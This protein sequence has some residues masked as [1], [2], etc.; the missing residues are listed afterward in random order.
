M[1]YKK[2]D[3]PIKTVDDSKL[4][5]AN[6]FGFQADSI[7]RA[8][9]SVLNR[10]VMYDGTNGNL[11]TAFAGNCGTGAGTGCCIG[12]PLFVLINGKLGT[13]GSCGTVVVPVGTQAKDTFV[14]YGLFGALGSSGTC[15]AGNE[16]ATAA[17]A[18][19]PDCP[20]GLICFGYM[21]FATTSGTAWDRG[22]AIVTG[23][24][25]ASACGTATFQDLW[26]MPY[27]L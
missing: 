18:K 22:T 21:Q 26:H 27:D 12:K 4:K 7:R 3:D 8:L 10:V 24:A 16:S 2:F 15:F 25:A 20:D 19:L 23:V 9:Q 13:R 6:A 11:S 17:G 1:A 5:V 14:K